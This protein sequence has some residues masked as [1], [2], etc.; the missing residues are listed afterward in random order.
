M[1]PRQ[2]SS[3]GP[4]SSLECVPSTGVGCTSGRDSSVAQLEST[5]AN[6]DRRIDY[7]FLVPGPGGGPV[8]TQTLDTPADA[9]G[10]ATR[11]FAD[12]PNPFATC[13]PGLDVC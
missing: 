2:S 1:R 10:T 9:D 13:G 4:S 8:C 6:V 3:N 11:I 7:L 12:D 5:V